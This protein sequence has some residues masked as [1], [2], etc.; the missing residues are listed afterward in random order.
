MELKFILKIQ[1]SQKKWQIRRAK[2]FGIL[3]NSLKMRFVTKKLNVNYNFVTAQ[4]D[5]KPPS[6]SLSEVLEL[7]KIIKLYAYVCKHAC[8][9]ELK[10]QMTT[11]TIDKYYWY[12]VQFLYLTS[13][14][15]QFQMF[16]LLNATEAGRNLE[17]VKVL[18]L[19]YVSRLWY[20]SV[21][22]YMLKIN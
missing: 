11:K 8:R 21:V 18:S 4:P 13:N 6:M 10:P 16:N 22:L 15:T 2:S 12:Y 3:P 1:R 19:K 7:I 9:K 5:R 17:A 14:F 20:T